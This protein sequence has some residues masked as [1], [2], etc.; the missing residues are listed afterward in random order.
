MTYFKWQMSFASNKILV[1]RLFLNIM[2]RLFKLL[3]K[4]N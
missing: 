4:N 3:F 1:S 2:Q